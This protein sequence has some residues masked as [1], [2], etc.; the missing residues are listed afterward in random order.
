MK[1]L[2]S[3]SKD[4]PYDIEP[5]ALVR[6]GSVEEE[7][8]TEGIYHLAEDVE[9]AFECF[10]EMLAKVSHLSTLER[11]MRHYP[12][13]SPDY[14]VAMEA[15]HPVIH[16]VCRQLGI[17][18][19]VAALED[20]S[21][22]YTVRASHELALEG[23]VDFL[24]DV[25]RH[26]VE[27]LELIWRKIRNFFQRVFNTKM[28]LEN[29]EKLTEELIQ[30]IKRKKLSVKNDE[31]DIESKL[32]LLLFT[33]DRAEVS[34]DEIVSAAMAHIDAMEDI[35]Q[36]Q[37]IFGLEALSK[38]AIPK[39]KTSIKSIIGKATQANPEDIAAVRDLVT[40]GTDGIE[41][42]LRSICLYEADHISDDEVMTKLAESGKIDPTK[43]SRDYSAVE[44]DH[45]TRRLPHDYN[46][47]ISIQKEEHRWRFGCAT[48]KEDGLITQIT[49]PPIKNVGQIEMLL[50]ECKNF[51]KGVSLKAVQALTEAAERDCSDIADMM[52]NQFMRYIETLKGVLSTDPNNI[53]RTEVASL[54]YEN[55]VFDRTTPFNDDFYDRLARIV[56]NYRTHV[57]NAPPDYMDRNVSEYRVNIGKKVIGKDIGEG[58]RSGRYIPLA[59][60]FKGLERAPE[61][62]NKLSSTNLYYDALKHYSGQS[63]F[64]DLD[65][66]KEEVELTIEQIKLYAS[67]LTREKW[68]KAKKSGGYVSVSADEVIGQ[69]K[70]L[71]DD[72][73]VSVRGLQNMIKALSVDLV[74][75][76]TELHYEIIR[77]AYNSCRRYE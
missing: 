22:S 7:M 63:D 69:L 52:R 16:S 27:F 30:K 53:S 14:L 19:K 59:S 44:G 20:F 35:F 43:P 33:E 23:F 75:L 51:D 9:L 60:R 25:W 70:D 65:I 10:H 58:S 50:K 5:G 71:S 37:V 34:G 66:T 6:N 54:F 74:A 18:N 36:R 38:R 2:F 68:E 15:I 8:G 39:F 13:G 29:Y 77:Y 4:S 12:V 67:G 11:A 41:G 56:S 3:D 46:I 42:A 61:H 57:K 1:K 64:S 55:A 40:E 73:A 62:R 26:I 72:I 32:N 17:R 76:H 49:L 48:H 31:D 24:R 21:S 28:E 45:P 47:Y